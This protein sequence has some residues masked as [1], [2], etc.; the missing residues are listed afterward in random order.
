MFETS[1]ILFVMAIFIEIISILFLDLMVKDVY[2]L[3]DII[4]RRKK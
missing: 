2:L 3:Q 4:L 1:V